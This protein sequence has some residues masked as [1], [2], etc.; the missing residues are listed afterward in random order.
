MLTLLPATLPIRSQVEQARLELLKWI[1]KRWLGI[2]QECSFDALEVKEI[3]DRTSFFFETF[4]FDF[5][6]LSHISSTLDIK[7]PTEDL[8]NPPPQAAENHSPKRPVMTTN[9]FALFT[10]F[11]SGCGE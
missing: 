8:L 4:R 10:Y 5:I 9:L 2:R 1:G 7:V 11:Q 3:N 6:F